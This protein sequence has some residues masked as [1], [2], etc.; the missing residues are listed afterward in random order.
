MLIPLQYRKLPMQVKITCTDSKFR[1]VAVFWSPTKI[2][3]LA[4]EFIQML[5][6]M[7]SFNQNGGKPKKVQVI[8]ML[9]NHTINICVK[10]SMWIFLFYIWL[11]NCFFKHKQL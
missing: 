4:E 5:Q 11:K 6:K 10:M 2:W 1:L 9:H 3:K 8:I 7:P